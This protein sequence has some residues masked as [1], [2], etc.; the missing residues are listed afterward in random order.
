MTLAEVARLRR[1]TTALGPTP[2]AWQLAE[3]AA[4]I[5]VAMWNRQSSATSS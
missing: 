2:F 1:W 5:E 4:A 3:R